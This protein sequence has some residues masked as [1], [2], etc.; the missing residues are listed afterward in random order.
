MKAPLHK[1]INAIV[2][3]SFRFNEHIFSQ[4]VELLFH[5]DISKTEIFEIIRNIPNEY[6]PSIYAYK[7]SSRVN[8][9]S[10]TQKN[11]HYLLSLSSINDPFI[12][13]ILRMELIGLNQK[14]FETLLTKSNEEIFDNLDIQ[15]KSI[16]YIY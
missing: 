6:N 4:S 5:K 1:K 12:T 2:S 7:D 16:N 11:K 9:F 8:M 10:P 14:E 3:F 15:V 13:P